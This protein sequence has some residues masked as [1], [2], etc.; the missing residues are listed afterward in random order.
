MHMIFDGHDGNTDKLADIE[1]IQ[2]ALNDLP[3]SIGTQK[4]SEPYAIQ[5]NDCTSDIPG[6]SGFISIPD[7]HIL[8]NTFPEKGYIWVDIF[9]SNSFDANVATTELIYAF[10][11]AEVISRVLERR[12]IPL[13]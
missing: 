8:I 10:D 6:V 12:P 3:E 7:G 4:V 13:G 1:I 11:L 5:Y 9:S 2:Q